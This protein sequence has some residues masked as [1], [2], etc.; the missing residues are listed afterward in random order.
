MHSDI[1]LVRERVEREMER[2]RADPER[3]IFRERER[4]ERERER[5]S[6]RG[7]PTWTLTYLPVEVTKILAPPS[8]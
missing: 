4:R 3:E 1:T 6:E 7:E 8:G 5:E 2:E